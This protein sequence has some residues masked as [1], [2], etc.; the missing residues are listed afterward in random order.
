MKKIVLLH[1][2]FPCDLAHL[3]RS[4][5]K[6]LEKRVEELVSSVRV[7]IASVYVSDLFVPN[8]TLQAALLE[9]IALNNLEKSG[10]IKIV[11]NIDEIVTAER[12]GKLPVMIS[13]EGAEPIPDINYLSLFYDLRVRFL[14]LTH[15]RQNIYACGTNCGNASGGLTSLGKELVSEAS[16]M[17][18][19][20]DISHINRMGFQDVIKI[21]DVNILASHSNSA[22][23]YNVPRN[24]T[25]EEL[26]A[27]SGRDGVIGLNAVGVLIDKNPS[28]H[29]LVEH[30]KHIMSV[31]GSSHM[32]LGMD[33][34]EK[35]HSYIKPA[36][37]INDVVN[38]YGGISE[39]TDLLRENGFSENDLDNIR[40]NSFFEKILP[41]LK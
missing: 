21:K 17:G 35:L 33:F 7:V 41:K 16:K 26:T 31:I 38:G 24:L 2:D 36:Y 4:K 30:A 37:P 27:I 8:M 5:S 11:T 14:G 25:D 32:A 39:F 28:I 3:L 6:N 18:M 40:G 10:L 23:I 1:D 13:L 12:S 29:K 15:N 9:I 22:S 19:V 34:C 20:I